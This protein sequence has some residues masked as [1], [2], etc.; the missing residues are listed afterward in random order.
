MQFSRIARCHLYV[1][2]DKSELLSDFKL[3]RE[4]LFCRHN[5]DW[6][7]WK[8][9]VIDIIVGC[10]LAMAVSWLVLPWYTS[11]EHLCLLAEAYKNAGELVE[12][13]YIT[14]YEACQPSSEVCSL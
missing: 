11:D 2:R 4:A 3:S 14:F 9:R 8:A 7:I 13:M 12:K 5:S 6:L 1:H 10:C